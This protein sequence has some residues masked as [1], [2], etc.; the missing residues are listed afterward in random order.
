MGSF[1]AVLATKHAPRLLP[2]AFSPF[3]T[4]L[5]GHLLGKV[6]SIF[7]IFCQ[8]RGVLKYVAFFLRFLGRPERST[9]WAHMQ[10][11]HAGAVQTHFF[12]FTFFLKNSYLGFSFWFHFGS[13]F[14][15]NLQF[16]V[17]HGFQKSLQKKCTAQDQNICYKYL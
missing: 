3:R 17:K 9:G 2:E 10:S 1:L 6:F 11:V 16:L 4:H 7:C 15:P 12:S 14:P 8:K 5:F 13:N